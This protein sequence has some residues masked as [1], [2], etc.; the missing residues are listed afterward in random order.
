MGE[1]LVGEQDIAQLMDG[2]Q[3]QLRKLLSEHECAIVLSEVTGTGVERLK[4]CLRVVSTRTGMSEL[5]LLD[6]AAEGMDRAASARVLCWFDT[7]KGNPHTMT[8]AIRST[9]NG[10]AFIICDD[11]YGDTSLA[12]FLGY[13]D[14]GRKGLMVT[15]RQSTPKTQDGSPLPVIMVR[16][17]LARLYWIS[18]NTA[19]M[20]AR[21]TGCGCQPRFV[22]PLLR[23]I[24]ERANDGDVIL[25][26][27]PDYLR[28]ISGFGNLH[29]FVRELSIF[30]AN[31]SWIFLVRI[32]PHHFTEGEL[33]SLEVALEG[34][35]PVEDAGEREATASGHPAP[36]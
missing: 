24:R 36:S 16:R 22:T 35:D 32:R 12:L 29:R 33:V 10:R 34:D 19:K 15:R 5:R 17:R 23:A 14:S 25:L 11:V 8:G 31:H 27:C 3:A 20:V 4:S 6:E 30:A 26:D 9:G 1:Q 7:W 28:D 13:L 21:F 2:M 18:E